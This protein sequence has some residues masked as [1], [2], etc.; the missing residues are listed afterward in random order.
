MEGQHHWYNKL[1]YFLG[2]F[3]FRH[4]AAVAMRQ[5]LYCR[6]SLTILLWILN[7]YFSHWLFLSLQY[8]LG[9]QLHYSRTDKRTN[10]IMRTNLSGIVSPGFLL[11]TMK[12]IKTGYNQPF[13]S[14]FHYCLLSLYKKENIWI[15]ENFV[16]HWIFLKH[17]T[18]LLPLTQPS[19]T[20]VHSHWISKVRLFGAFHVCRRVFGGDK[21]WTG[22]WKASSIWM[23]RIIWIARRTPGPENAV[24][25]S[26]ERTGL[27]RDSFTG[28]G[29]RWGPKSV[30][31]LHWL[32]ALP[33]P[34]WGICTICCSI[35]HWKCWSRRIILLKQH[36]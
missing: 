32:Q 36:L 14:Y 16:I 22:P 1:L 11:Y 27:P 6:N 34:E 21:I 18:F 9:M 19:L 4:Y 33:V 30:L 3:P 8:F 26:S 5:H 7:S 23:V 13:A 15:I 2:M 10:E 12:F 29:G 17:H 20:Y 24:W 31:E 35:R 28:E 25:Q